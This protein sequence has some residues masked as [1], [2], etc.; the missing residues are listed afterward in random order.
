M[1]WAAAALSACGGDTRRQVDVAAA[2]SLQQAFSRYSHELPM[3]VRLSFAGSDALAAQIEQGVRPDVFASANTKLPDVLFAKGLVERP[4]E[5]AANR[6]VVAVPARSPV[7]AFSDLERGGTTIGAG[8]ANVPVGAYTAQVLARLP[9]ADRRRVLANIVDREPDVTGIVGKLLEEALDAGFVYET[10]VNAT[11]GALRAI[12]LPSSLEPTIAYAA[13]V[14]RGAPN[15]AGARAFIA[16]LL[17]G[18]GRAD[19]RR[20]GFLPPPR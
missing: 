1:L 5:F 17:S 9:A 12:A 15:P 4:V 16:G 10:D 19:L 7:A 8:E 13:A 3:Q 18:V 2:A 14:V 20:D 11:A 6:L